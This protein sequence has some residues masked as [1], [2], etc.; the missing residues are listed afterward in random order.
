MTGTT[1]RRKQMVTLVD[2]SKNYGLKE[3]IELLK[4]SPETK[5]D[6]TIELSLKMSLDPR[7]ADQQVRGTVP[8]PH[9]TGKDIR[10]LVFAKGEKAE[11]ALE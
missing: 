6:Q 2:E 11:E 1:K 7:K 3:A 9:G 8:L 5:F 10:V 4:S